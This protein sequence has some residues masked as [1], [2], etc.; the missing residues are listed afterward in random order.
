M[1]M[2]ELGAM[3][4]GYKS[5]GFSRALHP[6]DQMYSGGPDWYW[7]V[8]E[9][10]LPVVGSALVASQIK[11]VRSVL[12][13]GSGYGRCARLLR[14]LFPGAAMSFCDIAPGAADFCAASF[15][16]RAVQ[17]ESLPKDI[18]VIWL[19]SVFTHIDIGRMK[20]LFD[21]LAGRLSPFGVL[22]ATT[23]GRKAIEVNGR[24]PYIGAARWAEIVKGYG[25]TGAGYASYGRESLGDYG[26][27]LTSPARIIALGDDRPDLRL[28]SYHEGG[29]ANHQ[30]AVAWCRH[31]LRRE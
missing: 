12:D 5:S 6:D 7:S 30:D 17:L 4:A 22:V 1:D 8:G 27:S 3:W 31:P 2:S 25:E 23:H 19:G 13:F 21:A 10:C 14:A 28:L 20:V 18:D 16:G 26:V 29:W 9:S 15:S 11:R 24:H